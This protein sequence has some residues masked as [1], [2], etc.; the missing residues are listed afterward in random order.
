MDQA[1]NHVSVGQL[2]QV[3]TA[4]KNYVDSKVNGLEDKIK[5]VEI[6]EAASEE[7]INEIVALFAVENEEAGE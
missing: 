6:P 2:S 4:Q 5:N 1:N 7:Q 3:A